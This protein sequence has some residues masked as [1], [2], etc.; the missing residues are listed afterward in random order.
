MA[1]RVARWIEQAG[2]PLDVRRVEVLSAR[3]GPDGGDV[4]LQVYPPE[5]G[6]IDLHLTTDNGRLTVHVVAR[7][8]ETGQLLQQQAGALEEALQ[9]AGLQLAGF[10]VEVG[11]HFSQGSPGTWGADTRAVPAGWVLAEVSP[12]GH[13][14]AA[15]G[16]PAWVR[17]G[18]AAVDVRV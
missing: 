17:L 11:Q 15:A 4:R 9:Q 1:E 8:P 2:R 14:T 3:L 12:D 6:R 18:M 16:R 13:E 10:S 5:L 7:H